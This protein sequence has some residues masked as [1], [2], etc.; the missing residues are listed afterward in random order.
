MISNFD[1][2]SHKLIYHPERISEWL[3]KG[4][5]FPIY[6]EAGLTNACNNRCVFC[7]LD[8][9]KKEGEYIDKKV[10]IESFKNISESGVK[11]IMFA[12][13]GE[14]LLHK[15][16]NLLVQKAK[17][18]E[19][20]IA[21]TTNGTLF[22]DD[23]I[24]NCLPNL[25]W[26][27]FSIDSGSPENYSAV[28]GTSSKNFYEVIKNIEKSVDFKNKNNLDTTIGT[29][30]LVTTK[31]IGEASKLAKILK[32][33]CADNLQI[34]P[35]SHHPHSKNDLVVDNKIYNSLEK[36][37]TEFDS[38]H[39]KIIFRKKTIERIKEGIN[40]PECYG[41]S[42]F[43]LIDSKG[44]VLPCNLFYNNEEFTYGNLYKNSFQEIWEG[45]KRKEI[46][47][48]LKKVG[49]KDCRMG[50]RLDPINRYL[51]RLKNPELHDKFI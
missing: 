2:D 27:R 19:L 24:R 4:D 13:E 36:E 41:S 18:V 5:C 29:Q 32:N 7:A 8:F 23:K 10:M 28:H 35:Y 48:K 6:L 45:K 22:N 16:I 49:T 11:S 44:N 17:E 9:L 26:I 31:N 37:L 40:Y 15:E 50:C 30:F 33:I 38:Q 12:G 25:S 43:S 51:H 3:K 34:K 42:F 21:I 20:D 14:P 47:E 46:L 1:V 39:F